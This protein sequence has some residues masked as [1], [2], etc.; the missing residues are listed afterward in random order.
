MEKDSRIYVAGHRG[1]VGSAIV[2]R[3]QSEGYG[4]LIT[5]DRSELD[6][7]DQGAVHRF[8]EAERPE[9]VFVSAARVGGILANDTHPADFLYE[10]LVISTNILH[11]SVEQNVE[12]LLY[13]GSSCVYPKFAPQPILEESLLTGALEPTNEG[14]ALA[15]I[16]GLKLCEMYGRQ[17]GKHFIAAMP[18]NIYG[19]HDNFHPEQSHV[20]PGMLRRFH[21]AKV[22]RASSV[23]I[24]GTGCAR[25]E[26]LYSDDVAE[27][28]HM[29]IGKYD[30]RILFNV[31]TGRDATILE[32]AHVIR[33]IVGFDGEILTD[34]SKPDG[35]PQKLLEVSRITGLGWVPRHTLREGLERTYRWAVDLR[36]LEK[37]T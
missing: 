18:S 32:L 23:T 33:E 26:L 6:L 35:T 7:L 14:Y 1:L 9:Y 36:A 3:L 24:W 2:R 30:D 10:N 21:T 17:Y 5:R 16:A 28:Q 12:K 4:R 29:L 37:T 25:R 13:L 27:A 22:E 20:V 11:A 34:L 15:K 31:G 19:P 8:F